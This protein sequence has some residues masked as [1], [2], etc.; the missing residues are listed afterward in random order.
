MSWRLCAARA[1]PV[2]V[3]IGISPLASSAAAPASGGLAR[4]AAIAAPD[5]RLACYDELA[6]RPANHVDSVAPSPGAAPT[7]SAAP[8]PIAAAAASTAPAS[9]PRN[10]GFTETHLQAKVQPQAAPQAPTTIEAHVAKVIENRG[11]RAYVVLDNGQTWTFVDAAED[12]RLSPGDSITI[13]KASLGSFLMLT[14]AK[15]SYHVRRTQ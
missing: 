13:K 6:G 4:C 7:S 1:V 14:Q 9:D 3:M 15:H 8:T 11:A 12:A 2:A 10:F 5:A